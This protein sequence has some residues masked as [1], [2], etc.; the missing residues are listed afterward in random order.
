VQES[1]SALASA[2]WRRYEVTSLDVDPQGYV[3]LLERRLELSA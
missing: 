1:P 2:F 3:E